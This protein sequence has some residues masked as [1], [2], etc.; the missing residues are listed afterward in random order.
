M[1]SAALAS[2]PAACW[3]HGRALAVVL[4]EHRGADGMLHS[5]MDPAMKQSNAVL[6]E[7]F[8]GPG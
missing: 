8:A 6:D 2:D 4:A 7:V 1:A 3:P 5:A